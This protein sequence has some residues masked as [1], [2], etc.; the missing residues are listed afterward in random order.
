MMASKY[1]KRRILRLTDSL[2]IRSYKENKK[3]IFFQYLIVFGR[4]AVQ[5]RLI[6]KEVITTVDELTEFLKNRSVQP[7]MFN[8][9]SSDL[10]SIRKEYA[11]R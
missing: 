11:N 10:Q 1:M 3:D 4:K 5:E 2:L 9:D 6:K 8:Y 7:D